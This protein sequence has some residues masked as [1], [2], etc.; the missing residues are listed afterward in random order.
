MLSAN[1]V[2][3]PNYLNNS[4]TPRCQLL[5]WPESF[6]SWSK[7]S[8]TVLCLAMLFCV[9]LCCVGTALGGVDLS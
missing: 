8:C 3:K 4:P 6:G 7:L 5:R 2:C 9:G 1:Q